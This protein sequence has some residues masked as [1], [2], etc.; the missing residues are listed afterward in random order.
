MPCSKEDGGVW[1]ELED[2]KRFVVPVLRRA[3]GEFGEVMDR[4]RTSS[5]E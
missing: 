1:F 3:L 4:G 2:G 5:I